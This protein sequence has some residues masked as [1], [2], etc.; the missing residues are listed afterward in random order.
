MVL[1]KQNCYLVHKERMRHQTQTSTRADRTSLHSNLNILL[2]PHYLPGK[3][4]TEPDQTCSRAGSEWHLKERV[5]TLIFNQRGNPEVDYL[6]YQT[7]H[8]VHN[9]AT[10][11]LSNARTRTLAFTTLSA[12]ISIILTW[13]FSPPCLIP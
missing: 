4:N 11:Y 1:L 2:L 10:L 12:N 9:H 6:A 13:L 5:T 3:Y 8:V 7:A